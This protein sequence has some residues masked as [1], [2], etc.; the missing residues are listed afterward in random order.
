MRL[1]A[2]I[3]QKR[4]EMIK[5]GLSKGLSDEQTIKISQEL[6]ELLNLSIQHQNIPNEK[7]RHN[8]CLSI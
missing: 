2:Q 7:E 5:I 1:S 8:K 3:E 6:D 4:K